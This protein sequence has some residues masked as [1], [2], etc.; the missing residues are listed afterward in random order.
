MKSKKTD[1]KKY[2]KKKS[3]RRNT[4][5]LLGGSS[6]NEKQGVPIIFDDTNQEYVGFINTLRQIYPGKYISDIIDIEI[7]SDKTVQRGGKI[8]FTEITSTL[9]LT[10]EAQING[11]SLESCNIL[12]Q[13]NIADNVEL[14]EGFFKNSSIRKINILGSI[15]IVFGKQC[16]MGCGYLR[17]LNIPQ[18]LILFDECFSNCQGLSI[19]TFTDKFTDKENPM[20]SYLGN[21]CFYQCSNINNIDFNDCVNTLGDNC[22]RDCSSLENVDLKNSIDTVGEGCFRSCRKLNTVTLGIDLKK[23][24]ALMFY[25]CNKLKKIHNLANIEEI[26]Y[27]CFGHSGIEKIDFMNN[28]KLTFNRLQHREIFLCNIFDNCALLKSV[29]LPPYIVELPENLF[30]NCANLN[31]LNIDF[32]K[33]VVIGGSCFRGCTNLK[34]KITLS[35]TEL[36]DFAF[37]ESGIIKVELNNIVNIPKGLLHLCPNLT[38][39]IINGTKTINIDEGFTA[40]CDNLRAVKIPDTVRNIGSL[41]FNNCFKIRY[42]ILPKQLEILPP[43]LFYTDNDAVVPTL[44]QGTITRLRKLECLF[45]SKDTILNTILRYTVDQQVFPF[46][47]LG[48]VHDQGLKVIFY[49]VFE[50]FEDV[51]RVANHACLKGCHKIFEW[52]HDECIVRGIYPA[53]RKNRHEVFEPSRL[54]TIYLR[55]IDKIRFHTLSGSIIDHTIGNRKTLEQ[56]KEACQIKMDR[57]LN[58]TLY[59]GAQ[60]PDTINYIFP[61]LKDLDI[62][63]ELNKLVSKSTNDFFPK[64]KSGKSPQ[65][66]T[67]LSYNGYNHMANPERN[68]IEHEVLHQCIEGKVRGENGNINLINAVPVRRRFFFTP[69][70]DTKA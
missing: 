64:K 20:L 45:I 4:S 3:K 51:K 23:L 62:K 58:D 7:K 5:I 37:R 55:F 38:K 9:T 56:E 65:L 54:N 61:A 63:K 46:S 28:T 53:E 24:P 44:F 42:L 33:I 17:T 16:F 26:D 59:D 12:S 19:L 25:E 66:K 34:K 70:R 50:N 40:N 1:F 41:S 48:A 22:F 49:G 29:K 36:G 30:R 67:Y 18:G 21:K 35:E 11:K 15:D 8:F 13:V 68:H 2:K 10:K 69:R 47:R 57:Y 6:P 27:M 32:S 60:Y 14:P 43:T 39:V 52:K 31:F